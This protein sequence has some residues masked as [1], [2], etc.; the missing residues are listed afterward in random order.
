MEKIQKHDGFNR[1]SEG[2]FGLFPVALDS[3][4]LMRTKNHRVASR[5]RVL[6]SARRHLTIANAKFIVAHIS[7][8]DF[9]RPDGARNRAVAK[10]ASV[11]YALRAGCCWCSGCRS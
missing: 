9:A 7:V 5:T 2:T 1:I 3:T 6:V 8:F 10:R 11:R 4:G